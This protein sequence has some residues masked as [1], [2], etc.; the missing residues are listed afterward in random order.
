M[1]GGPHAKPQHLL[2]TLP[3]PA[4]KSIEKILD[5]IKKAHPQLTITYHDLSK[6]APF[7]K[8][9]GIPDGME[10]SWNQRIHELTLIRQSYRALERRQH[11]RYPL[12]AAPHS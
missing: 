7:E 4:D 3:F 12:R 5:R 6:Q 1:G 9:H 8:D 10:Q 2:C 11:P